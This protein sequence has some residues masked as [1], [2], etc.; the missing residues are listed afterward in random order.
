MPNKVDGGGLQK[1]DTFYGVPTSVPERGHLKALCSVAAG[2]EATGPYFTADDAT[3]FGAVQHPGED[4]NNLKPQSR[5]NSVTSRVVLGSV[6][7]RNGV[8]AIRR[9]NGQS[10]PAGNGPASKS[11]KLKVPK[12]AAA[13]G[14][15]GG[16]LAFRQHRMNAPLDSAD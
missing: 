6:I 9:T 14:A 4:G 15:I 7:S 11:S 10:I 16:L 2:A 5:W 13:V 8:I 1:N 3:L 12:G